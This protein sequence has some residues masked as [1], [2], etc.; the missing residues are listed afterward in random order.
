MN[1]VNQL[2]R[3]AIQRG[4]LPFALLLLGTTGLT[5]CVSANGAT[6]PQAATCPAPGTVTAA[7][8]IV[9]ILGTTGPGIDYYTA[10]QGGTASD[11]ATVITGSENISADVIVN[12]VGTNNT[13]PDLIANKVLTADGNNN[14][15][16]KNN[17]ACK[18]AAVTD[19]VNTTLAK[20]SAPQPLDVFDALAT[21]QG[22]LTGLPSKAPV[23]VVLLTSL[24]NTASPV[25]LSDPKVLANPV[26][27][28]NALAA[29]RLIPN[30][31]GWR[32]AAV[33]GD[34]A[35]PS[36]SDAQS[37]QLREF[38]RQYFNRCG[39]VLVEWSQHLTTFPVTT[40]G[41]PAADISQIPI[42]VVRTPKTIVAT[43]G[44]DVLFDNGSAELRAAAGPELAQL[45][46]LINGAR[47]RI[48]VTGYT[49]PT[50][51]EAANLILSKNRAASVASWLIGNGVAA[52][53]I[54]AKG[55]GSTDMVFPKPTTPAEHQANRRVI[56]TIYTQ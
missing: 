42:P 38:W 12:G 9:A 13:A 47:G 28:L 33:G 21:L 27:A 22:N 32:V 46:Q 8:P 54:Q 16:R 18:D 4:L 34:H 41:I 37:A 19:A 39:G 40:A 5:G 17:L 35:S 51:N 55:A 14:L 36:L 31:E 26:A 43:L 15:L 53:R 10:N 50:G 7:T 6:A 20:A 45:L 49:D 1:T 56:V 3:W 29:Q 11:L 52:S 23:N 24:V 48:V 44:G 2:Y 30:C 25:N